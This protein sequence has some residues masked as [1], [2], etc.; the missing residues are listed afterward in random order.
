MEYLEK[1]RLCDLWSACDGETLERLL[2]G[3]EAAFTHWEEP[4]VSSLWY[5][6]PEKL[7]I[8][9]GYRFHSEWDFTQ[10]AAN[11]SFLY[12]F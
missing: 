4:D 3:K 1:Y 7:S 11:T 2:K 10:T 5:C 9:P 8:G 12:L 6:E